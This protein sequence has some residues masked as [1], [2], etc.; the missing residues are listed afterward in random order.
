METILTEIWDI[1]NPEAAEVL[2]QL[3]AENDNRG[4]N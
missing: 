4:S 3:E 1:E 2:K